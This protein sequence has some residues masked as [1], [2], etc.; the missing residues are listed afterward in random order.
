MQKEIQEMFLEN[1]YRFCPAA[2]EEIGI[3]YKYYQEGFHV[4]LTVDAGNGYE[5]TPEMHAILEERALNLFYHPEG[6]LKDFPEGFPVYHVETLT[7]IIGGNQEQVQKLCALRE[8]VWSYRPDTGQ[9]FIYENQPGD[10]WGLRAALENLDAGVPDTQRR[11]DR[12]AQETIKQIFFTIVIAVTNIAVFLV[13]ECMGSTE[14]A[15][16]IAEHGGMYPDF[17]LYNGQWWRILTA[18]FIHFGAAHLLNNMVIFCCVGARLERTVGHIRFLFIYLLSGIGGGLLSFYMM[19]R[20]GDYAVSAGAS[21]AVFG[22]IGGLLWAVIFHRGHLEGL[23]TRGMVLMVA[24]SLYYGFSTIGVDNWCHVGGIVTG[25][26]VS[27]ILYHRK[28]QKY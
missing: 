13:M 7:L 17:I 25:F 21:G 4:V 1:G 9:L 23:T 16:F 22:V 2:P 18:M 8:R 19:V 28:R 14:N 6:R 15:F 10:F 20:T 3:F 24:L 12:T 11:Q 27:A 26:V 5:L